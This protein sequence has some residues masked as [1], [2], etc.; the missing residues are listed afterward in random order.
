MRVIPANCFV[1]SPARSRLVVGQALSYFASH[2]QDPIQMQSVATALGISEGCLDFCFDQSRGMTPFEALQHHR[3]NQLFQSIT[4]HPRQPLR[5]A[6]SRCGLGQTVN[7]LALF[8]ETFGIAMPLFV[9]TCRRAAED[10]E[11]RRLHPGRGELV[12]SSR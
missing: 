6:I 8:E 9:L 11:F 12:L 7:P 10:R 4:D 5:L 3:L 1:A 2:F